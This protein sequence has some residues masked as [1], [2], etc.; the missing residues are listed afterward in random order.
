LQSY[1]KI[2]EVM[3]SSDALLV[4]GHDM[5]V[6]DRFTPVA[7][8][9]VKVEAPTELPKYEVYACMISMF[10]K[11][12][13]LFR[14]AE[15]PTDE[16][17]AKNREDAPINFIYVKGPD[18]DLIYG[19]GTTAES[20]KKMM[21]IEDRNYVDQRELLGKLGVTAE[22]I[23]YVVVDHTCFDHLGAVDMFPN[24]TI[25]IEKAAFEKPNPLKLTLPDGTSI[26]LALD[27]D[28]AKLEKIKEEGR[29]LV[30]DGDYQI[31]P[32]I[33]MYYAPG[34]TYET[35][36]LT[37]FWL[38]SPHPLPPSLACGGTTSTMGTT[39]DG[40]LTILPLR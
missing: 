23:D 10:E 34:H 32:G 37:V 35:N 5:E 27:E 4:P 14:F 38:C 29:L 6:Y 33:R 12:G 9:I 39:M 19:P 20:M 17:A 16:I 36:F 21:G 1:D 3:G 26:R 31:A 13:A 7:D 11:G 22:D 15:E 18:I 8:R 40:N 30:V 25:I 24:A 28:Y 2:R